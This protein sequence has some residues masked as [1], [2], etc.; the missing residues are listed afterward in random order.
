MTVSSTFGAS[1]LCCGYQDKEK[2]PYVTSMNLEIILTK[3]NRK[4]IREDQTNEEEMKQNLQSLFLSLKKN[5]QEN[6][7]TSLKV[8]WRKSEMVPL[9]ETMENPYE[10][11]SNCDNYSYVTC[12]PLFPILPSSH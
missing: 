5:W 2:I 4:I 7:C 10:L 11:K 1:L 8:N 12:F 3:Y 9:M 6:D